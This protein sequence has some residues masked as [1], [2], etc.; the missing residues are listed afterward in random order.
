MCMCHLQP[1]NKSMYKCISQF[2]KLYMYNKQNI[3]RSDNVRSE[4]SMSYR[5]KNIYLHYLSIKIIIDNIY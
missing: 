1:K 3:I 4:S 2:I 5:K